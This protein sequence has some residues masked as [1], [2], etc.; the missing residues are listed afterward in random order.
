MHMASHV[1]RNTS[2]A[3]HPEGVD[4]N[5]HI[6]NLIVAFPVALHPEGVDRNF[7]RCVACAEARAVALHPEGVDRNLYV[8][9]DQVCPVAVA[10]HPEGVDRNE[11]FFP[12]FKKRLGR[13]PPGGRG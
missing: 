1:S 6:A 12:N 9:H 11:K 3:L 7:R 8:R 4:R 5:L 2:V 10:L 13:P